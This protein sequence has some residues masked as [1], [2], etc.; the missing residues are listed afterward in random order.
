MS[1]YRSQESSA[2]GHELL[3]ATSLPVATMN[4]LFGALLLTVLGVFIGGNLLLLDASVLWSSARITLLCGALILIFYALSRLLGSLIWGLLLTYGLMWVLVY[5]RLPWLVPV[6]HMLAVLAALYTARFLRVERKGVGALLLMAVLATATILGCE[7]SYTSFDMLQRLQIGNVNHDTLFH[8]SIAAMIKNYGVVST[9]LHGLVETPYHTFSHVLMAAISLL[10][11][12]GVIEVY[13]VAPWVLFAPLLIF[14]IA[15]FCATLD[16]TESVSLPLAWGLTSI[17]LALTPFLLWRW[18]VYDSF[19]V[20]E[21]YLVSLGLFMFGLTLL[22]KRRLS[23]LD[24]LPVLLLTIL[25]SNAKA[26]VGL[27]FA[28]LWFTR[29]IFLREEHRLQDFAAFVL[30]I[31]AVGWVAFDSAQ[32]NAGIMSLSP[33]HFIREYSFCGRHLADLGKALLAGTDV[34][35]RTVLLAFFAVGSFLTLHFIVSWGVIF[36]VGYRSGFI[37][38][39]R[40]PLAVYSLAAVLAGVL[41]IFTA[42]IPGGSEYY[43]SNV[44]FFVSLPGVVVLLERKIDRWNFDPQRLLILGVVIVCLV[45]IRSFY[46]KSYLTRLFIKEENALI[47]KL[48]LSREMAPR[49]LV[50]RPTAADMLANPVRYCL[51]RPFVFPAVSERAWINVIEGGAKDCQYVYYGYHQYGISTEQQQVKVLPRLLPNMEIQKE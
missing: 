15:A 36:Q 10:S 31:S 6:F 33:L 13:G 46:N 37:G 14:S 41:I 39:I 51:G 4:R 9:G 45:G 40:T 50:L 26:S 1:V 19:F 27:I 44:A 38:L 11:G 49:Y 32:A 30:S 35:V 16:R 23:I 24:L 20:S 18:G 29:L 17:L 7:T 2:F 48:L 3:A 22:F 21:S 47:E 8:A 42:A 5:S 43:F 28:G 25:M 12:L 34:S